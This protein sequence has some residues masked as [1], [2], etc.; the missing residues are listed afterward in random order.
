MGVEIRRSGFSPSDMAQVSG[1]LHVTRGKVLTRD[2]QDSVKKHCLWQDDGLNYRR[3]VMRLSFL[4]SCA[5]CIVTATALASK[6]PSD[7]TARLASRLFHE[8]EQT[9]PHLFNELQSLASEDEGFKN[10]LELSAERK[11]IVLNLASK[12]FILWRAATSVHYKETT[13]RKRYPQICKMAGLIAVKGKDKLP[14]A[15]LFFPPDWM[16]VELLVPD[17][18]G[19]FEQFDYVW[20]NVFAKY[21]LWIMDDELWILVRTLIGPYEG[22]ETIETVD[23]IHIKDGKLKSEKTA[24]REVTRE[25]ESRELKG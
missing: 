7:A 11:A 6:R 4:L 3:D 5:L 17:E 19:S 12:S 2:P 21:E 16:F 13:L 8:V 20:T 23:Y 22:H 24:H 15:I 1:L 14:P 10:L 18:K 25:S 9:R